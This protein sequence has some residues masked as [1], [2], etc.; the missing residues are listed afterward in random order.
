[1]FVVLLIRMQIDKVEPLTRLKT[2]DTACKGIMHLCM[3]MPMYTHTIQLLCDN[4]KT[5]S[6]VFANLY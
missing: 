1:M 4:C 3:C 6:D 2:I 5:T